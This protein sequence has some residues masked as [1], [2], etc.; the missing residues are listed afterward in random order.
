MKLQNSNGRVN[1]RRIKVRNFLE[2]Q[3][4]SGVKTEKGTPKLTAITT[5]SNVPL[6]ES[7]VKRIKKEI[8][9]LDNLIVSKDVAIS[10]RTK[11]NRSGSRKYI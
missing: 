9:I 3:L 6:T 4:K 10:T 1:E 11:K 5:G 7:D 2:N 8:S